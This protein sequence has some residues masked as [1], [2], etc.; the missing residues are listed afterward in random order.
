[1]RFLPDHRDPKV[2][3]I[4]LGYVGSCFAA[5]LADRG[6]DVTGVDT[7]ARLIDE[8]TDGHCRYQEDGLAELLIG[9]ITAGRLRVTTDYAAIRAADVVLIAVGTPVETD[10]SLMDDQL[11]GAC[12]NVSAHLRQGQLLVLKSTVPPGTTRDV[13]LPLLQRSGLVCGEDFGLAF[14]PERFAEGT[15]LREV[16][17]LPIVVGGMD[18]ASK[19]DAAEFW[20]R[21][22]GVEVVPLDSPEAAEIVKL[23]DNWWIDLNIALANELAK[24]CGAHN[25]DVLD[26]IAAA[27]TVPKG[28][29]MVNILL[30]SV[31]VGGSC[32]VKDPWMVWHSA[33]GR[34]V[35]IHTAPAGRKVNLG[36]PEYTAQLII[37]ELLRLGKDPATST[38]AV[39]GAAFKNNTGDLRATP[40]EGVVT[41]L[42]KAG[43]T[44]RVYDPLVDPLQAEALLGVAP[45]PSLLAAVQDADCVA[46]MAFHREFQDLDY[47][48][49]PVAAPCVVLDGR[50]YYPK[51]KIASLRDLGYAYRG[52]GR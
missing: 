20:H 6:Y 15:A 10:G 33:R 36:M 35:E 26:V 7:D 5:V 2:A 14:T 42:A 44:V 1:M 25:V 45:V 38:V 21:A 27:N 24:F 50:A 16:R 13:V 34:G 17:S 37:D 43:A 39:L 41:A 19:R 8:L 32:L 29:G 49:L 47:A 51:E 28:K 18:P 52:I 9:G 4:G 3:I 23:A 22:L 46:I 11:R 31:G 12:L 40:V 48:E 30:P